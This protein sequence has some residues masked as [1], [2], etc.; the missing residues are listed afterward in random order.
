MR[1]LWRVACRQRQDH[2]IEIRKE[3]SSMNNEKKGGFSHESSINQS[4]DWYTP[5]WVF[6]ALGLKF[7]LDPCQPVGGIDWIPTKKF[8]T[9]END[10]LSSPWHGLVW[11][12]PPYGKFTKKWLA[13]MDK[14][15]NGISLVFARTDCAWFHEYC[16]KADAI[17][18]LQ[19]RI[20]FVDGLGKTSGGGAGSGSMLIAWGAQSVDALKRMSGK[21]LL[22]ELS[23]SQP[24]L[25][26]V[27]V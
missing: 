19:G 8:Y 14:H 20:R 4:V 10:G 16:A 7:D 12:N 2:E 3:V 1:H 13:K 27:A 17:L 26:E 21:G 24:T 18:F 9:V 6:D 22:V 5:K 15:R 25:L 23:N 11:L